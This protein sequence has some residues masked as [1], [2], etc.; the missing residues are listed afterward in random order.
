VGFLRKIENIMDI[1]N[2][3]KIHTPVACGLIENMSIV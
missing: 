3:P 2:D 1:A